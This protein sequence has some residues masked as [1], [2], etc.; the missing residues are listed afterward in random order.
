M[1]TFA[2]MRC[3]RFQRYTFV[4]AERLRLAALGR[5]V[6][7][8]VVAV[9]PLC[10]LASVRGWT[11]RCTRGRQEDEG[12]P[13]EITPVD[14]RFKHVSAPRRRSNGVDQHHASVRRATAC[15]RPL[16]AAVCNRGGPDDARVNASRS[17]FNLPR[18]GTCDDGRAI[19][20]LAMREI[21]EVGTLGTRIESAPGRE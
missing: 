19:V 3:V 16:L 9:R 20:R 6:R 11:F 17:C 10:R 14:V 8:I 1:A 5:R 2:A 15:T 18:S 7:V 13:R 12:E 21:V 4:I